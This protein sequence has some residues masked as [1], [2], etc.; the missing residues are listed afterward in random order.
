MFKAIV[1]A[2]LLAGSNLLATNGSTSALPNLEKEGLAG[3]AD[4]TRK[5][6]EPNDMKRFWSFVNHIRKVNRRLPSVTA[7]QIVFY[8]FKFAKKYNIDV[9]LLF[10]IQEK[11]STFRPRARSRAGAMG[12]GQ[13]MY[14]FGKQIA[15]NY[16][17]SLTHRNDL[18]LLRKNIEISAAILH[19]LSKKY[20]NFKSSDY[21][22]KVILADYNGGHRQARRFTLNRR[23]Y[24]ETRQYIART[25]SLYHQFLKLN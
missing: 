23:L 24:P 6:V 11:E 13:I 12:L 1:I 19:H 4:Y 16:S 18:Y 20:R 8:N 2:A 10:A 9:H 7:L 22:Y 25:F 3:T 5:K 14:S 17:I 15:L 21:R